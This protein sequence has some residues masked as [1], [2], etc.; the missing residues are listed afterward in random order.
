MKE[1]W[2]DNDTIYF[3]N[4]VNWSSESRSREK[5]SDNVIIPD[6][7]VKAF[8]KG[9]SIIFDKRQFSRRFDYDDHSYHAYLTPSLTY[10]YFYHGSNRTESSHPSRSI[11]SDLKL[12]RKFDEDLQEY[13]GAE[14]YPDYYI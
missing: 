8:M 12:I 14:E 11:A 1:P 3:R 2:V 4:I 10:Y 5:D 7:W 9:D 6:A 13:R